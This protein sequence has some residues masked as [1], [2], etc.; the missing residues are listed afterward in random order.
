MLLSSQSDPPFPCFLPGAARFNAK[1]RFHDAKLSSMVRAARHAV[2][3]DEARK[4]FPA[5]LWDNMD[6][7]NDQY[8]MTLVPEYLQQ[9]F[10]GNHGSVGGGGPQLGLSSAALTWVMLGA[11]KHGLAVDW[12]RFRAEASF[13]DVVHEPLDNK[14]GPSGI[15][16]L[17]NAISRNRE[18]PREMSE[19]SMAAVDRWHENESYRR[20][21]VLSQVYADLFGMEPGQREAM[22]EAH[23]VT[24]GA[25]THEPGSTVWPGP[26]V[27]AAPEEDQESEPS[28]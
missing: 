24:D 6:A 15:A 19:L 11:A 17:L 16:G 28:D 10:P 3:I 8:D 14:F 23:R 18:G 4:T 5:Y 25:L 13:F 12:A 2:S 27:W 1:Y 21:P 9:W 26:P 22:R 7:L 20:N